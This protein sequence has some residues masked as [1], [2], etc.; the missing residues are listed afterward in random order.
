MLVVADLAI[1]NKHAIIRFLRLYNVNKYIYMSEF[2]FY[3]KTWIVCIVCYIPMTFL[4]RKPF[5]TVCFVIY[6][7]FIQNSF[8]PENQHL[9]TQ[10][11]QA[12]ILIGD[13]AIYFKHVTKYTN[14]N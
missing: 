14:K 6:N 13:V 12:N 9:Q 2:F 8:V 11:T 3:S 1:S 5:K 10:C 7:A 4:K